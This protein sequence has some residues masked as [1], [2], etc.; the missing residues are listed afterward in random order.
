MNSRRGGRVGI[1]DRQPWAGLGA[2]AP[3]EDGA[4]HEQRITQVRHGE[5]G[6]FVPDAR[7][8]G[9]TLALR[10]EGHSAPCIPASLD[11][12]DLFGGQAD[13]AAS[14]GQRA[15][16]HVDDLADLAER[17]PRRGRSHRMTVGGHGEQ[18]S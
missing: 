7:D 14:A 10:V 12:C 15:L 5:L 17:H 13:L 6:R 2:L 16:G 9:A 4:G 18:R 11:R 8:L 1:R 3:V